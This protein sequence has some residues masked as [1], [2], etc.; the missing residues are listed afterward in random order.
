MYIKKNLRIYIHGPQATKN[1]KILH[2]VSMKDASQIQMSDSP[3]CRG[4]GK[5]ENPKKDK[6]LKSTLSPLNHAL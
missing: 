5:S 1:G 3:I 2:L 6:P 4:R